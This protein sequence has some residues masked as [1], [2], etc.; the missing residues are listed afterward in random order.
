[1]SR[2]FHTDTESATCIARCLFDL[3]L[4][5][6]L[7]LKAKC[8]TARSLLGCRLGIEGQ[9]LQCR[10]AKDDVTLHQLETHTDAEVMLQ[11]VDTA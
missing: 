3:C 6:G 11:E 8:C 2:C 10:F 1:M 5:E 4:V 7:A 9:V